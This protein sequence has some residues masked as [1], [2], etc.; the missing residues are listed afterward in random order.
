[1]KIEVLYEDNDLLIVN[2]PAGLLVIPDRFD[3]DLPSLNKLLEAQRNEKIWVV[4]RLDRDTSGAICFAKN[5]DTHKYLSKL[6]QEHQVEKYYVGLVNGHVINESDRIEAPIAEHPSKKG[7]MVVAKKGKEAITEYTILKQWPLY[8]YLQLRIYT[9]RTH[10]IRVHMQSIG[11]AIVA[12]ELYGDGQPFLLSAIKKKYKLS[13]KYEQEKPLLAR[14][15]LHASKLSF[16]KENGETI[17]VEAPV[18]KDITACVK[19]L[20]KWCATS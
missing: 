3:Q 2:K 7:R 9:G 8:S 10:Q 6:F 5:E 12:D 13:T 16:K 18:P 20:D 4:H 19:Q 17:T 1:M 11:H 15:G 14:L